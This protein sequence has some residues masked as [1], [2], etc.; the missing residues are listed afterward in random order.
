MR[1]TRTLSSVCRAMRAVAAAG[2]LLL[3]ALL[4]PAFAQYEDLAPEC[5]PTDSYVRKPAPQ[6]SP[7]LIDRRR[8]AGASL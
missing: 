3:C 7:S 4:R 2:A 1:R 6:S 5:A 8:A